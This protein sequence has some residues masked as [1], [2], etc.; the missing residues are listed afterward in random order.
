MVFSH[1]FVFI[2]HKLIINIL[3]QVH[4]LIVEHLQPIRTVLLAI[5][6]VLLRL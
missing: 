2:L 6:F 4:L 3:L 1:I 5:L